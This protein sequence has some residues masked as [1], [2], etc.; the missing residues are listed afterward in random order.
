M[1]HRWKGGLATVSHDIFLKI[2]SDVLGTFFHY[3][4][5]NM[6]IF[7]LKSVTSHRWGGGVW[8]NVTKY[9]MGGGGGG[10]KNCQKS[11]KYYLN[12]PLV[13]CTFA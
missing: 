7:I 10:S 2:F 4:Y 3:Y 11:V 6:F 13:S 8:K 12:G 1:P 9:H 5:Q